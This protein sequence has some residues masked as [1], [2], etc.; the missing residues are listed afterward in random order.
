MKQLPPNPGPASKNFEPIL[1]SEPMAL[2]TSLTSA[3]V[4]SQIA[5]IEFME[6]IL[7]AKKSFDVSFANSLLQILVCNIL[8]FGTHLL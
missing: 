6:L 4:A 8:C 7:W 3:P 5:P 2:A 1:L